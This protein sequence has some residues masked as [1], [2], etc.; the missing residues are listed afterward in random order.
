L[1]LPCYE[2]AATIL[3]GKSKFAPPG[4]RA[5]PCSTL[6]P[7]VEAL[8]FGLPIHGGVLPKWLLVTYPDHKVEVVFELKRRALEEVAGWFGC[9]N[10][11]VHR[12]GEV[13]R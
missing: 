12:R 11:A 8:C 3:Q 9:I 5:L 2:V 7:W 6:Q 13:N 4:L 10:P 1:G